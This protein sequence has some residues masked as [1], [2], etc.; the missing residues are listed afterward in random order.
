L[1]PQVAEAAALIPY[2]IYIIYTYI[3]FQ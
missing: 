2:L 3:L 1:Q